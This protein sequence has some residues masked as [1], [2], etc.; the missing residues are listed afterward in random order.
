MNCY[1][2]GRPIKGS[3][4]QLLNVARF[5]HAL[6]D[7]YGNATPNGIPSCWE[8]SAEGRLTLEQFLVELY[9][10]ET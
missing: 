8:K 6:E 9:A 4:I 1:F 3:V 5:F 2:C 7:E 10:S